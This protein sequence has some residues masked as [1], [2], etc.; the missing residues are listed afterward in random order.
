[1][2]QR[3][4]LN[5]IGQNSRILFLIQSYLYCTA[6]WWL[7]V[8]YHCSV[9]NY[10]FFFLLYPPFPPLGPAIL[11][12]SLVCRDR[13]FLSAKAAEHLEHLKSFS[14]VC[15]LSWIVNVS[16]VLSFFGQKLHWNWKSVCT[17]SWRLNFSRLPFLIPHTLHWYTSS[18]EWIWIW[19]YFNILFEF[20]WI[21]YYCTS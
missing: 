20:F 10:T 17:L 16:C 3:K 21:S 9:K 2:G 8:T 5:A 12:T 19:W 15:C 4:K 7:V 11:W 1:M 14:P 6:A 13:N 18:V